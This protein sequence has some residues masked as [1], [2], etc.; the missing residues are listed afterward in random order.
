MF[1]RKFRRI[2]FLLRHQADYEFRFAPAR[3]LIK[4]AAMGF[5]V[6]R[7][8]KANA[9]TVFARGKEWQENLVADF[10]VLKLNTVIRSALKAKLNGCL[11][12]C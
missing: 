8:C 2:I 7:Q 1:I 12:E 10:T 4:V 11:M 3:N 6:F 5:N 9:R